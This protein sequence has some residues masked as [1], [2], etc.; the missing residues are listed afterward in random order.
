MGTVYS[1]KINVTFIY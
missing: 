1:L